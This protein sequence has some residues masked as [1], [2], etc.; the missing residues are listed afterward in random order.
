MEADTAIRLRQVELQACST[1]AAEAQPASC[2][3]VAFGVSK[4]I[5][6]PV[7]R[8]AEIET[9]VCLFYSF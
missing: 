3:S 6:L 5:S 4:R 9:F 8:E 2:P 7:F 1:Q